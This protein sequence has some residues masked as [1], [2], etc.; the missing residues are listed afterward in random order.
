MSHNLKK[1]KRRITESTVNRGL[2]LICN[3]EIY[4]Y[5][6]KVGYLIFL[7]NYNGDQGRAE[8]KLLKR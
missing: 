8:G 7:K 3:V 2:P 1:K 5:F 4:I 6:S